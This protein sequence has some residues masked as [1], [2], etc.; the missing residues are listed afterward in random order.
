MTQAGTV[1]GT[2]RYMP[3]EQ[4]A[5]EVVD[6]RSDV[7]ALGAILYHVLAGQPPFA[8]VT[9][10]GLAAQVLAGEVADLRRVDP[11]IPAE[12]ATIAQRAMARAPADRY[13]DAAAFAEELRRFQAG[14]MV[15][16]HTYSLR[17]RARLWTRTH[18]VAFAG[19]RLVLAGGVALGWL[20]YEQVRT[21][22]EA[23]AQ[24][25]QAER[26]AAAQAEKAARSAF[27]RQAVVDAQRLQASILRAQDMSEETDRTD[28]ARAVARA[29]L[30][31]ALRTG[32]PVAAASRALAA[33][34]TA[35]RAI[36]TVGKADGDYVDYAYWLAGGE[37]IANLVTSKR[38]R[39][40]RPR[41][42]A[43][44][45]RSRGCTGSRSRPTGRSSPPATTGWCA[46]T[47]ARAR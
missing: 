20:G 44:W 39:L 34:M 11:A 14:Q 47:S 12:L 46:A 37:V 26:E 31:E 32:G 3:P 19:V 23:R 25:E 40:W 35:P 13:P 1:L 42:G 6:V 17:E 18:P 38:M 43:C 15:A 8:A 33:A 24:T 4:A 30:G 27:E 41:A 7:Y 28:E 29:A 2:L 10:A 45:R 9:G 5:G 16:A 21:R 22:A 36:T